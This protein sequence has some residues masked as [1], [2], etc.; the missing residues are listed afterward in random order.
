VQWCPNLSISGHIYRKVE[1][2]AKRK[3]WNRE[4][5]SEL[6]S[7]TV[8]ESDSPTVRFSVMASNGS[9]VSMCHGYTGYEGGYGSTSTGYVMIYGDD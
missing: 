6:G 4:D 2:V 7:T 5:K 1:R 9:Y 8:R 3:G